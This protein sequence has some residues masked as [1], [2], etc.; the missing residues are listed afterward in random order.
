[1]K[2]EVLEVKKSQMKCW[3]IDLRCGHE[4]IVTS[5]TKPKDRIIECEECWVDEGA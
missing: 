4:I 5:K 2:Q 3:I 1:M